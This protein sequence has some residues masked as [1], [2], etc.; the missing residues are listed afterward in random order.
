MPHKP[1]KAHVKNIGVISYS[2]SEPSPCLTFTSCS[3]PQGQ[4]SKVWPCRPRASRERSSTAWSRRTDSTLHSCLDEGTSGFTHQTFTDATCLLWGR[5]TNLM[6]KGPHGGTQLPRQQHLRSQGWR[7][8]QVSS[9]SFWRYLHEHGPTEPG[10]LLTQG[11]MTRGSAEKVSPQFPLTFN[12]I[13]TR[14]CSSCCLKVSLS[15]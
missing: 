8:R 3:A 6:P 7:S 15:T 14:E 4:S 2:R 11:P 13:Q 9:N 12:L 5:Q 1:T 10:Q